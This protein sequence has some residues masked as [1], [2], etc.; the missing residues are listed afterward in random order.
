MTSSNNK[1]KNR[2]PTGRESEFKSF[3]SGYDKMISSYDLVIQDLS[4]EVYDPALQ[5]RKG[6]V[7]AYLKEMRELWK[8][9]REDAQQQIDMLNDSLG[10]K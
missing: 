4:G 7:V 1:N 2:K 9:C 8:K 6:P 3:L 5:A 10:G